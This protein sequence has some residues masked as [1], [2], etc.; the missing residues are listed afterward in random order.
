MGREHTFMDKEFG[1]RDY[2]SNDEMCLEEIESRLADLYGLRACPVVPRAMRNKKQIKY[3]RP[4]AF[5]RSYET[6][7]I[8]KDGFEDIRAA[9]LLH[10]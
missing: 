10:L 8:Y 1:R 3:Q 6:V 2:N 9:D 5:D 4:D 7:E